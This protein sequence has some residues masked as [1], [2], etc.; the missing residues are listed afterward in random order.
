MTNL[1]NQC[2]PVKSERVTMRRLS[3]EIMEREGIP[4]EKWFEPGRQPNHIAH[5]RQE[6]MFLARRAGFTTTQIGNF[7][8]RDHS[9]VCHG[10]EAHEAR[11]AG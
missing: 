7:L 4:H 6:F 8:G 9:T 3:A 1:Q 10:S 11:V 5:P 2:A